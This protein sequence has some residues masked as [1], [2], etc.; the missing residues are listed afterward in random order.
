[1]RY[2]F[3][4]E[5][6]E[7]NIADDCLIQK[8]D[9]LIQKRACTLTKLSGQERKFV[10]YFLLQNSSNFREVFFLMVTTSLQT[11]TCI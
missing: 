7:N 8:R 4:S 10:W 1:M 6:E 5:K 3:E 11:I 9:C 2:I